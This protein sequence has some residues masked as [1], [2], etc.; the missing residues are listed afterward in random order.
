MFDEQAKLCN[1]HRYI[2]QINKETVVEWN[3]NN[4]YISFK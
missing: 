3:F 1:T 4:Y 2:I